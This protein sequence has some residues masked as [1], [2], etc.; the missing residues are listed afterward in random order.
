MTLTSA[1]SL[2]ILGTQLPAK[3][4]IADSLRCIRRVGG[5]NGNVK[6]LVN[7]IYCDVRWERVANCRTVNG[8]SDSR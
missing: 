6:R 2:F 7:R 5:K 1:V 3:L 8:V 4:E